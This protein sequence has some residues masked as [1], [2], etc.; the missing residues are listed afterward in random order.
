VADRLRG[1]GANCDG[2][3]LDGWDFEACLSLR[4]RYASSNKDVA[5]GLLPLSSSIGGGPAAHG[6]ALATSRPHDFGCCW[7]NVF[8]SGQSGPV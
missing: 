3:T 8:A 6:A 5:D 7:L 2:G 4:W 1:S